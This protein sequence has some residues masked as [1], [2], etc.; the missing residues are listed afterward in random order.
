[1]M[2]SD[3]FAVAIF[4]VGLSGLAWGYWRARRG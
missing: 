2:P 1:M 4:V 3:W